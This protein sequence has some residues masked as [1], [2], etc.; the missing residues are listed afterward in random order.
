MIRW[1]AVLLAALTWILPAAV[2]SISERDAGVHDWH[3]S[4]IGRP[5]TTPGRRPR[6]HYPAGR[7]QSH[8]SSLI[9]T[10]TEKNILAAIEPRLGNLGEL[11]R[12]VS[13]SRKADLWR[14][15]SMET[16]LP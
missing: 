12:K 13:Q 3:L 15:F 16:A 2:L 1:L 8:I 14:V 5:W 6:F 4:L 11:E 9:Y 10:A 7:D